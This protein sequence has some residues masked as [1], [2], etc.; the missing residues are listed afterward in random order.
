MN[1]VNQLGPQPEPPD[2]PTIIQIILFLIN[3][4]LA[5]FGL[6]DPRPTP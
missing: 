6:A 4:L 1:D 3:L 2:F 5:I